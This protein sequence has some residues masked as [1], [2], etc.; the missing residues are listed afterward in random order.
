MQKALDKIGLPLMGTHHRGIDD[1]RNIAKIAEI[2]LKVDNLAEKEHIRKAEAIIKQAVAARNAGDIE[3]ALSL[4]SAAIA[5]N[6]DG[7][8]YFLRATTRILQGKAAYS[9]A[10]EDFT[11]A[12]DKIPDYEKAFFS[13]GVLFYALKDLPKARSDFKRAPHCSFDAFNRQ[14][15][16][17]EGLFLGLEQFYRKSN[18]G[19]VFTVSCA[20][21]YSSCFLKAKSAVLPG[22]WL[23]AWVLSCRKVLEGTRKSD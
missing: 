17:K 10:I 19:A 14:E 22:C 21:A 7:D 23:C 11:A 20:A 6:Q 15:L 12:I 2:L 9:I 18:G 4:F 1:A 8:Y 16:D 13:R 3:N 5:L